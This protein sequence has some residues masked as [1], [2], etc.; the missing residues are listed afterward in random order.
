MGLRATL[1]MFKFWMIGESYPTSLS[2]LARLQNGN[3]AVSP[4]CCGD[5][6]IQWRKRIYSVCD[7]YPRTQNVVIFIVFLL[8]IFM[9]FMYYLK[10]RRT[11]QIKGCMLWH[12]VCSGGGHPRLSAKAEILGLHTDWQEPW[13]VGSSLDVGTEPQGC[14]ELAAKG[15]VIVF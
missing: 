11:F 8:F 15:F 1:P 14:W 12:E 3:K 2:S 4:S 6:V 13:G 10:H 9:F 7:T 5:E